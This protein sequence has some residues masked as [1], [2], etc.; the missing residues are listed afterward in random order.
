MPGTSGAQQIQELGEMPDLLLRL[1]LQVLPDERG[2]LLQ[3][4]P[5]LPRFAL[6]L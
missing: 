5:H 6:H 4:L 2:Q 1:A 3:R